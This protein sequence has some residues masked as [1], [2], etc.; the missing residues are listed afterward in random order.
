MNRIAHRARKILITLILAWGL[1][2][3]AIRLSTPLLQYAREPIANWLSKAVGQ[4]VHFESVQASWWGI[5]PRL[6]FQRVSL[7]PAG[8]TITVDSLSMDLSHASLLKGQ[9]LDALRLTL[10]GFELRLVREPDRRMHVIGIP[11]GGGASLPLPRHLRLRHTR[12]HW[13]DHYKGSAPVEIDD[14]DLD[15]VR[16]GEELALRG[17]LDSRL[18]R[19]R[20][21]TQ[22]Q[23]F[24]SGP[25]WRGNSY[26]KVEGLALQPLL[27]SYMPPSLRLDDGKLDVELWQDW[28][29]AIETSAR[30]HFAIGQLAL[31]RDGASPTHFLAARIAGNIDYRRR[32]AEEWRIVADE[33]VLQ[34]TPDSPSAPGT[35]VIQRSRQCQSRHY[36][37]AARDLAIPLLRDLSSLMP[38]TAAPRT[39]LQGLQPDGLVR[40]LRLSLTTGTH[41]DWALDTQ[42][43][44]LSV[45]AWKS[46]PGVQGLDLNLTADPQAAKVRLAGHDMQLD[47]RQLFREPHRIRQLDGTLH[48]RRTAT[49]WQLFG[50]DLRFVTP[51]L[52]GEAWLVIDKAADKA[53]RLDLHGRIRDGDVASTGRYLPTAIMSDKVVQW[54]DRALGS[55]HLEQA[56]VLVSGPLQDFPFH[57]RRSGV[58]EVVGLTR[59][60]PLAYRDGWPPLKDVRAR[61]FFHE[62]SLDIDL[63]DGGIYASRIP[64]A[65]AHIASLHPG[66]PLQIK[67]TVRGPLADEM[68]LLQAPALRQRF[69]HIAGI[70]QT[71]GQA[72]LN[73]DFQVPLTQGIGD[74]RLDGTLHF[75][76][77][78]LSLKGWDLTI[79]GIHGDLGIGLDALHAK[80][81]EGKAFGAPLRVDVTPAP[82][83]TRI[84]ARANWP[85]ETLQKRFPD[86][87]LQL[88]SGT[89][90]FTVMLDIPNASAPQGTP[91][92]I[93]VR[94]DLKGMRLAL[95]QPLGKP[96]AQARALEVAMPLG[97]PD[98][99]L[100]VRYGDRLDARISASGNRGEIR[101]AR[102]NSRLPRQPGYRLL[103]TLP[104]VDMAEWQ[105]LAERLGK[106]GTGATWQLELRTPALVAGDIEMADVRLKARGKPSAVDARLN[107]PRIAGDI[108]YYRGKK[109]ALT[110]K[111]ER[112]HLDIDTDNAAPTPAPDPGRGPDPR[113]L[114]RLALQCTDLQINK[115]KLG[116][117]EVS[118]QP[119]KNG[120]RI[121]KLFVKGPSGTLEAH[122][123]WLWQGKTARTQLSGQLNLPD[124]GT[125]LS[126]LGYPR[127]MHDARTDLRFN[128]A[129]L[130]HPAQFHRATLRGD[131]Y[132]KIADGRLSEVDPGIA[133]VL[134]LVS[135]DALKRRLKFDF[136]DLLKKGYSFDTIEGHFKLADGQAV[137]HDLVVD[138]PSGRIEIGGRIGL[139]ARDFD[140]VIQ[141]A[142]KLDAALV[143]ASTIAG[144]PVAGA[145]TFVL[146][147]LLSE[148][149]DKI[150][151]FEYSVTGSW[152]DPKLT[153]LKSGGPVSAIV[154]TLSGE[155]STTKTRKQEQ[156]IDETKT[157]PKK[158]LLERLLGK[159]KKTTSP[160]EGNPEGT[161][162]GSE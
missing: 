101:Y 14:L 133:R 82:A 63:L 154:N 100:H 8:S 71:D 19:A 161:F 43:Q 20:F 106:N 28:E 129:W 22:I 87:P 128:L 160:D 111:L 123:D 44:G 135:L 76:D 84:E 66:G 73:L 156:A 158:G 36:E 30:G 151:R 16:H 77:D 54:L 136:G 79:D 59:D 122:G 2:A 33:L 162:P 70:M 86:L 51:D 53:P 47:Y 62:N 110:I 115:A 109:S 149:V 4:P 83:A 94:S 103:A 56:D 61:L 153:P 50:D 134:G 58:F 21:S 48:W 102:G 97:Q 65:H 13:E 35:L 38:D 74:Y 55:G 116:L 34:A 145:A 29:Q 10:D 12:L 89:A 127:N 46:I 117:F 142:P 125:L 23:G 26:L 157:R 5:G 31:S 17:R 112:L 81:I 67:G 150:N 72:E 124:L 139:V 113:T 96:A 147:R 152:D 121:R 85:A 69:G 25:A 27:S 126:G 45:R 92:S 15:L 119:E 108:H 107:S 131:T 52:H 138:G 105:A 78:R 42:L 155:K 114:P 57:E 32:N 91:V 24:L 41:P 9:L 98:G 6:R 99:T 64:S 39:A 1:L 40:K 88:A 104:R 120:S 148:E 37:V 140:Q 144:G 95:P 146:Q 90:D 49:G 141:V 159:P 118:L 130:G 132:L 75:K 18:G 137:T 11:S 7:G 143:I 80:D 68:R 93:D 3:L 60:T